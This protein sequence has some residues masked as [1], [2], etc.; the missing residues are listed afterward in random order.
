MVVE[1][2]DFYKNGNDVDLKYLV[3]DS[4]FTIYKNLSKLDDKGVK[5]ITIRRRGKEIFESINKL[6]S[7]SLVTTRASASN[8]KTRELR[9]SNSIIFL[10]DYSKK[11]RQVAITGHGK[12]KPALIITNDFDISK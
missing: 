4:K 8:G 6:S 9:V 7:R 12:I 1:F 2:L 11:I 3:F 5:F 10:K